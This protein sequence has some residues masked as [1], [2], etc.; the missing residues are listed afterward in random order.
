MTELNEDIR[1]KS[2]H[3]K[4]IILPSRELSSWSSPKLSK[5]HS[6]YTEG[7]NGALTEGTTAPSSTTSGPS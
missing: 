5:F 1:A 4:P 7:K 2:A 6:R 3:S